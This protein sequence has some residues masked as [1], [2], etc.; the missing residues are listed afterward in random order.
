MGSE[1]A[2]EDISSQEVEK[3]TYKY[4][5]EEEINGI[6]AHKIE[7][8]P[9]YKHSGY[10]RL[11]NWIDKER[12]VSLKTEFYDRKN[13]LLKTLQASDYQLYKDKLWRPGKLEMINEQ[14]RKQTLL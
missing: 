14:T 11:I 2:F 9:A 5:G 12:L 3:Y 1:F 6:A 10:T 8:Y 4:L 7:S 13:S